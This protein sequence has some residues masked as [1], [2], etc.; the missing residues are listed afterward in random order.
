MDKKRIIPIIIS[1]SAL[2]MLVTGCDSFS[3]KGLWFNEEK[4]INVSKAKD[5]NS[6]DKCRYTYT[7]NTKTL[8]KYDKIS[9]IS[10]NGALNEEDLSYN[11]DLKFKNVSKTAINNLN[12]EF[13]IVSSTTTIPI[14]VLKLDSVVGNEEF[15]FN[16]NISKNEMIKLAE[17][18]SYESET[19][20]KNII[21]TL[22]DNEEFNLNYNY[23]FDSKEKFNISHELCFDGSTFNKYMTTVADVDNKNLKSAHVEDGSY[24]NLIKPEDKYNY[25]IVE[26][27]NVKVDIDKNFN[28]TI[29]AKF[30]NISKDTIESFRFE[31][32]I[33]LGDVSAPDSVDVKFVV[34]DNIKAG[35]EF[36]AIVTYSNDV[37][38]KS[39][40]Y[41][42]KNTVNG[43]FYN[44]DDKFLRYLIEKRF[45]SVKYTYDYETTDMATSVSSIISRSGK[46][47]IMN[48]YEYKIN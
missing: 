8:N 30:K 31:P 20:I 24:L 13:K 35:E 19:V 41:I 22:I 29:R 28:F 34:K 2:G 15:T 39:L 10:Y 5:D 18:N 1:A 25:N 26:T 48:V 17:N 46:L 4:V 40:P 7:E 36:D 32:Y 27:Q 23:S 37:I 38:K 21:N 12:M 43:R 9:L 14:K 3:D 11:I 44:D 16:I 45:A 47:D 33:L 42:N 6:F